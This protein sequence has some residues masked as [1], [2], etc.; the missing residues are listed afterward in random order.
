MSLND[1]PTYT[2]QRD[3]VILGKGSA[4]KSS[5]DFNDDIGEHLLLEQNSAVRLDVL[6]R[7]LEEEMRKSLHTLSSA[8]SLCLPWSSISSECHSAGLRILK[9]LRN[10][11]LWVAEKY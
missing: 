2:C 4:W 5:F 9:I 1:F 6:S 10:Y 7:K 8:C 3:L 11:F